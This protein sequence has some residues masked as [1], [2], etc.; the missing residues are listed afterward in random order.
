MFHP[1]Q[2][3]TELSN[4][5][6]G[7]L[8]IVGTAVI[9]FVIGFALGSALLPSIETKTTTAFIATE[10]YTSW[11]T[12]TVTRVGTYCISFSN[13]SIATEIIIIQPIALTYNECQS[14]IHPFAETSTI[15][16]GGNNVSRSSTVTYIFNASTSST[17]VFVSLPSGEA[18]G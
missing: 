13:C 18:C 3:N 11:T 17:T 1:N 8:V 15:Y 5:R 4:G 16:L 9:M 7:P 6:R 2:L 14:G 10:S 12:S